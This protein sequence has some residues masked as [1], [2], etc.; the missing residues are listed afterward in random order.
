MRRWGGCIGLVLAVGALAGTVPAR[1]AVA[2]ADGG[3]VP[4]LESEPGGRLWWSRLADAP[5]ATDQWF[6]CRVATYGVGAGDHE[7]PAVAADLA[8]SFPDDLDADWLF[9]GLG[10]AEPEAVREAV[11]MT[12]VG[13]R[14]EGREAPR[15]WPAPP[16]E[17]T[18]GLRVGRAAGATPA[19]QAATLPVLGLGLAMGLVTARRRT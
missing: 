2:L 16:A 11:R 12:D 4:G 9:S 13:W 5:S 18:L 19:P 1:A 6:W 17:R 10:A 14:R 8:G 15:V 3:S 7:R